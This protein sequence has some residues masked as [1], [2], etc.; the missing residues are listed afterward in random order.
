MKGDGGGT[1]M[2]SFIYEVG[3]I[4]LL[5]LVLGSSIHSFDAM[6]SAFILRLACGGLFVKRILHCCQGDLAP[7]RRR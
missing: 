1:G 5:S 6:I 2:A 4:R 7:V 3:W